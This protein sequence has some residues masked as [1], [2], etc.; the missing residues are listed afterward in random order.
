MFESQ[1]SDEQAHRESDSTDTAFLP[2]T[3]LFFVIFLILR[4][5]FDSSAYSPS[6]CVLFKVLR[7]PVEIATQSGHST[8][9][10]GILGY[11]E[12]AADGGSLRKNELAA[13]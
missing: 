13:L 10:F 3:S 4:D 11:P 8:T 2:V 1:S 9:Y 12:Y 5:P 6:S 7:R